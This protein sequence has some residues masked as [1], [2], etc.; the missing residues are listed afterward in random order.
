[1]AVDGQRSDDGVVEVAAYPAGSSRVTM[2]S[3]RLLPGGHVLTAAHLV[4]EPGTGEIL[5]RPVAGPDPYP[6]S[7]PDSP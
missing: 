4:P 3:G 7:M 5:V 1:M 6:L 2:G